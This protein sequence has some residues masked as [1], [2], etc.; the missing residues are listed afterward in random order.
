MSHSVPDCELIFTAIYRIR[1]TRLETRRNRC[2]LSFLLLTKRKYLASYLRFYQ[3]T[4]PT[5]FFAYSLFLFIVPPCVRFFHILCQ[6]L[7]Q[8]NALRNND[9]D[10]RKLVVYLSVNQSRAKLLNSY[11]VS[12]SYSLLI[13]NFDNFLLAIFSNIDIIRYLTIS[14]FRSYVFLTIRKVEIFRFDFSSK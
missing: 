12:L 1:D 9:T 4:L 11:S 2:D 10:A 13:I 5:S 3:V 8:D 14:E 6:P 7:Q